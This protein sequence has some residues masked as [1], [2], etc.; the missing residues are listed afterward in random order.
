[1]DG[2]IIH[3]ERAKLDVLEALERYFDDASDAMVRWVSSMR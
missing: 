2:S 3:G 1:M